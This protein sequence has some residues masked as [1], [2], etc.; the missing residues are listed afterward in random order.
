MQELPSLEEATRGW[1][2]Q[3]KKGRFEVYL[4][5][6]GFSEPLGQLERLARYIIL[7]ILLAGIIVGSAIATG[8]AAAFGVSNSEMFTTIAF[9]GYIAATVIAVQQGVQLHRV[10]DVAEIRQA[11]AICRAVHDGA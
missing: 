3:Y 4:D 9:S 10:H 2:E 1:L 5:T 6:S 8:I 11:L 7:G